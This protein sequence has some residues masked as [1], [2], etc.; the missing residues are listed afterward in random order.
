MTE[1]ETKRRK[2]G[3]LYKLVLIGM[4]ILMAI[5]LGRQEYKIY[6]LNKEAEA[7]RQ[8]VEELQ[9]V[10]AD[11]QA[12]RQRLYDPKYIEKLARE[13]HN[14][15]GKNE[16]PLFIVKDKQKNNGK[17]DSAA[18]GKSGTGEEKTAPSQSKAKN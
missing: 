6:R 7:T 2:G 16:V 3:R 9:K 4:I 13:D 14:M 15:V 17:T 18:E 12:E 5:V 10:Q 8:R 1:Q 11:L